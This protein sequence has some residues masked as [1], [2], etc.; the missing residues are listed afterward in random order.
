MLRE[1]REWIHLLLLYGFLYSL[2]IVV[3]V[4]GIG[5]LSA[6]TPQI[7]YHPTQI[8]STQAHEICNRIDGCV[9]K[10]GVCLTCIIEGE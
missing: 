9:V 6:T 2:A 5:N 10:D 7:K 8:V 4:L 1:I 3:L